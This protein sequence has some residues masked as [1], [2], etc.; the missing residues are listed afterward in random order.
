MSDKNE[1]HVK[2]YRKRKGPTP[3]ANRTTTGAAATE[4]EHE[5]QEATVIAPDFGSDL[6]GHPPPEN[7][8][9]LKGQN[10]TEHIETGDVFADASAD[11]PNY[12]NVRY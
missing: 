8:L 3:R 6:E 7:G 2:I 9:D 12:Q 5:L 10:V 1:K 11:G 4:E